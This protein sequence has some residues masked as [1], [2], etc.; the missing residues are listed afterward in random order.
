MTIPIILTALTDIN[1]LPT[2][3]PPRLRQLVNMLVHYFAQA[4]DKRANLIKY[5]SYEIP[6]YIS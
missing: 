5:T 4:E 1:N 2:Q 6:K 3:V